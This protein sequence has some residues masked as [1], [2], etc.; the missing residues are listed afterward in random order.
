MN[1]SRRNFFKIIF[2]SAFFPSSYSLP[3]QGKKKLGKLI[4]PTY[5]EKKLK[6]QNTFISVLDLDSENFI[7]I[8]SNFMF[9]SFEINPRN[10]NEGVALGQWENEMA[11]FDLKNRRLKKVIKSDAPKEFFVGHG[12][13]SPDGNLFYSS[14]AIYDKKYGPLGKGFI[15]VYNLSSGDK[16]EVFSTEGYEPHGL[17]W[18]EL[19][20]KLL[21][22]NPG[23]NKNTSLLKNERKIE[24]FLPSIE[25][26]DIISK[27]NLDKI[28]LKSKEICFGHLNQNPKKDLFL[29]GAKKSENQ[30]WI[31]RASRL[32][33]DL[34]LTFMESEEFETDAPLL[35]PQIDHDGKYAGATS[36]TGNKIYFWDYKTGKM[37]KKIEQHSPTGLA[38][39]ADG[40]HFLVAAWDKIIL[41][42][43]KNL[44]VKNTISLGEGITTL[45][46]CLVI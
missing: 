46:H 1:F 34:K 36:H 44:E 31:P 12:V 45:S 21:V 18:M 3:P 11:I 9:H 5:N 13:Y 25:V 30:K 22:L 8:P 38:L 32:D 7:S 33:K 26:L 23:I 17:L 24:S 39:S 20:K 19:N 28:D 6:G 42:D 10:S 2:A 27:K 14:M 15:N 41:I 29:I 37:V 35:S 43:G 16:I 40:S 4:L